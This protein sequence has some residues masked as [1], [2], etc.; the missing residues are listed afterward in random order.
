MSDAMQISFEP[1]LARFCPEIRI[2]RIFLRLFAAQTSHFPS[3]NGG[4]SV[5]HTLIISHRVMLEIV[6]RLRR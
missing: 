2:L 3:K 6:R 4:A 1:A 5:H